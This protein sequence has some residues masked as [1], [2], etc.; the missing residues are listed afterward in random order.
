MLSS[1]EGVL[2]NSEVDSYLLF[3]SYKALIHLFWDVLL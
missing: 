1:E 2:V 3:M